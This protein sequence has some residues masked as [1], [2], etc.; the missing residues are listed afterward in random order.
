MQTRSAYAD[1][2]VQHHML[3]KDLFW[4]RFLRATA[5][6]GAAA[7]SSDHECE[8]NIR[9]GLYVVEAAAQA[10]NPQ[11]WKVEEGEPAKGW[12]HHS[13]PLLVGKAH[14]EP[15][16]PRLDV[17]AAAASYLALP[18]R[19]EML[20]R[21]LADMLMASEMFAFADEI[22]WRL[23]QK[24]PPVLAWLWGNIKS[25]I[26]GI[27]VAAALLWLFPDS[28][29]AQWTAGIIAGLTLLWTAFSVVVF[30]FLYP[31]IR[32]DRQKFEATV[33]GMRDA[34]I[35]LGGSPAS[36]AHIRKLVD[37]AT[38]AGVVWPAPLMALLDDI[39]ERRKAI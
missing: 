16:I 24:L 33:M 18:F 12:R 26:V 35:S 30:P 8:N 23:K 19:V 34:Y 32:S 22:Q 29:I 13:R 38:D 9:A 20:D 39:A 36:V 7:A 17:E 3:A 25:L 28:A 14:G 27:V 5:Q 6:A 31:R 10:V 4:G 11:L 1:R 21:L 15:Y 37:R 2:Q